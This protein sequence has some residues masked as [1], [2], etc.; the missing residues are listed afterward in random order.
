[1][2]IKRYPD[3]S[4]F[5]N[6]FLISFL[7][8][9]CYFFNKGNYN[10]FWMY[11]IVLALKCLLTNPNIHSRA[12]IWV[13]PIILMSCLSLFLTE[14]NFSVEK[15]II[16]TGKI[17]LC[18]VMMFFFADYADT[19]NYRKLLKWLTVMISILL[20]I[21]V[22]IR[23]TRLWS[24]GDMVN[25]YYSNRLRLYCMEPSQL[26][27]LVGIVLTFLFM[28]FL[29]QHWS[30]KLLVVTGIFAV[31][32]VLA[33]PMG[34]IMSLAVSCAYLLSKQL[35]TSTQKR[36]IRI[37][38][39]FI[40]IL[41]VCA[42]I[43]ILVSDNTI[44]ARLSDMI[45]G[46]DGSYNTRINLCLRTLPILMEKTHYMGVGVGNINTSDVLSITRYIYSNSY[47]DFLGS[48]GIWSI[49]YL[50][51]LYRMIMRKME[52]D[53]ALKIS[54]LLYLMVYQVPGGYFTD[55]IIWLLYGYIMSTA[56]IFPNDNEV[57]L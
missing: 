27:F 32:L 11:G 18:L 17:Y 42:V 35:A 10:L 37:G 54:L 13:I 53:K 1:M 23:P 45:N 2:V 56:S 14:L 21:A 44:I 20:I 39:F 40:F 6:E 24:L 12:I 29:I 9:F 46:R 55:P 25:I 33:M 50:L 43:Y 19:I 34:A 36:G 28:A 7:L 41:F 8:V 38:V 5:A 48:A 52:N 49:P 4:I 16:T 31:T 51:L 26:G 22:V 3:K 30:I 47:L 57:K 15:N